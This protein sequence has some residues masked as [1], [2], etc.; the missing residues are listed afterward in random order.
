MTIQPD[1]RDLA[2]SARARL[3]AFEQ[4]LRQG[5]NVYTP[6]SPGEGIDGVVRRE[7]GRYIDLLVRPSATEHDPTWFTA[8]PL[9]PREDL[10]V[11]CV[12]W[13]LTPLQC[14]VVPSGEFYRRA[15]RLE[16]GWLS[17]NLEAVDPASGQKHKAMLGYFRNAWRLITEGAVK[18][19]M[20]Y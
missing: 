18:S 20:A 13:P 4:L 6:V 12:A 10:L 15:E 7:D 3:L 8:P 2:F 11:V 5:V 1:L 14:W 17:L 16:D 9:E 19:L